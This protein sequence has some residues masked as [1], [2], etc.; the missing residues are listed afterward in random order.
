[1][2]L[3]GISSIISASRQLQYRPCSSCKQRPVLPVFFLCSRTVVSC[4]TQQQARLCFTFDD[5]PMSARRLTQQPTPSLA[6]SLLVAPSLSS[7][8]QFHACL[9]ICR[10][11]CLMLCRDSRDALVPSDAPA[12]NPKELSFPAYLQAAGASVISVAH[13]STSS[14][15]GSTLHT[16]QSDAP[17]FDAPPSLQR[18]HRDFARTDFS[19]DAK[20]SSAAVAPSHASLSALN[21]YGLHAALGREAPA[22]QPP[23]SRH[24]P[25]LS[26]FIGTPQ[27]TLSLPSNHAPVFSEAS[28]AA[29]TQS[30]SLAAT[31]SATSASQPSF[32]NDALSSVNSSFHA[33]STNSTPNSLFKSPANVPLA[34][35]VSQQ[36]YLPSDNDSAASRFVASLSES[37]LQSMLSDLVVE[38]NAL[39]KVHIFLLIVFVLLL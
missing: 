6:P 30:F 5:R 27:R 20:S 9:L 22:S 4:H 38:K 35:A 2:E 3:S 32:T 1:V 8:R 26:R 28:A 21:S 18:L 29:N 13:D 19:G 25:A 14:D 23:H 24:Q 7:S 36:V 15:F 33:S 10:R 31:Q 17:H 34:P 39:A 12:F 37:Q 16:Y 11:V